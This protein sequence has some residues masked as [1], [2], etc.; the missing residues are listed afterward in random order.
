MWKAIFEAIA[1]FAL[2]S[3][4]R[5]SKKTRNLFFARW[6]KILWGIIQW[7]VVCLRTR[8][9]LQ[10]LQHQQNLF[11]TEK[12]KD[13]L[14]PQNKSD[15]NQIP[16]MNSRSAYT[17]RPTLPSLAFIVVKN[18]KIS[19]E[20]NCDGDICKVQ[21]SLKLLI[22]M[23]CFVKKMFCSND[24][25]VKL[26]CENFFQAIVTYE[27]VRKTG[28]LPKDLHGILLFL[29]VL[30]CPQFCS[31]PMISATQSYPERF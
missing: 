5:I 31:S 29:Q 7:R 15:L 9:F 3:A 20:G 19:S 8:Q 13:G 11:A 2:W 18:V 25:L 1:I 4:L 12:I 10:V 6:R 14:S 21:V 28:Q 16:K 17:V 23:R 24:V 30:A 22:I 26:S 27:S